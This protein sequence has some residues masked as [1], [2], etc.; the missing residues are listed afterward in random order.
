MTANLFPFVQGDRHADADTV[1]FA[2]TC[3]PLRA[4]FDHLQGGGTLEEFLL[5]F[6]T[7][8]RHQVVSALQLA[9]D[10]LIA[11]SRSA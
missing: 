10:V 9:G 8:G 7:V 4:L 11:G 3:V 2:G 1:V 5:E 6:P